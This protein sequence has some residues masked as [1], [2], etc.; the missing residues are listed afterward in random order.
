MRIINFKHS[1]DQC[2]LLYSKLKILKFKDQITYYNCL[3]VHDFFV[4]NLPNV[5]NNYFSPLRDIHVHNTRGRGRL[6]LDVP[7]VK[8]RH[9]GSNSIRVKSSIDWNDMTDKVCQ[10]KSPNSIKSCCFLK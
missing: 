9:Y 7:R 8:T 3:F 6:L 2:D 1:A 10:T 4:K 5:F